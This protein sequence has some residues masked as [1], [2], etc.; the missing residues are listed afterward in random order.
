VD[1]VGRM[2]CSTGEEHNLPQGQVEATVVTN[3]VPCLVSCDI[4]VEPANISIVPTANPFSSF[5]SC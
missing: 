3:E 5:F 1:R 2:S 4:T